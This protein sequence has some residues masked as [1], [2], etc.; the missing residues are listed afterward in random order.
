MWLKPTYSDFIMLYSVNVGFSRILDEIILNT[1]L[2][3]SV[4]LPLLS[5]SRST[6]L[7]L[8]G[9]FSYAHV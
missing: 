4:K 2:H 6:V 7:S 1:R 5:C 8:F 3:R 9:V